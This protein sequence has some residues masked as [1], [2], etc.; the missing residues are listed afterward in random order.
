[1]RTTDGGRRAR[2][3]RVPGAVAL[4][5]AVAAAAL[6]SGC[7]A[8]HG[9]G[10]AHPSAEQSRPAGPVLA[11]KIDNVAP[12][13]PQTGLDAADV[14][15]VE[16]VEGG[17]SRLMAVYA[18][19]LPP[20]VGPVRSAR[21][22]DLELLRQFHRPVLA[23]SGAQSRLLPLI[24]AAPLTAA[25]PG[26]KP[27]A[28]FRDGGRAAPHNL[29][30][31]PHGLLPSA[32]GPGALTTGFRYGPAPAGGRS[33]TTLEVRYPAARFTFTWAPD[34]HGWRVAMDGTPAVT[35]GGAQ[36]APATVVVQHV[37]VRSSQLH[38][39]LGNP[40]PYTET[41]G[42]GTAEVLRDGRVHDVTWTR[43]RAQDGTRFAA[44]DGTPV[45]FA[46]GQVWVVLTDRP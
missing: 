7:T 20:V 30:V 43:A 38:D 17:L 3:R 34:R 18:T 35:A 9:R 32:P 15:Y 29:Y 8:G 5:A 41:V 12:A 42:S 10:P 4:L 40:T 36:L 46:P 26:R 33:G 28:Y 27:G 22:S 25:P 14:V 31:R 16:Q 44:A 6:A 23:F 37:R 19:R 11:V 21:A 1:M 13:R 24:D 2:R 45:D 39:V